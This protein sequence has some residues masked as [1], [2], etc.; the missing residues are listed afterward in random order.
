MAYR[1]LREFTK[2][3][4]QRGLLHRVKVEVDPVLEITEITD[5]IS[6]QGGP[7]LLF[8]QVR[9]S[10]YPVL[11]NTFGSKERMELAFE[12]NHLDEIGERINS[13]FQIQDFSSSSS[14]WD[15]IK[16]LPRLAEMSFWAPK[17]VK[18]APC[19]EVVHI[20]DASLEIFPI[21]K[22]WPGDGGRYITLPLVFTKDPETGLRNVGMYRLQVF[23]ACTTG[24]HW[25][26]HKNGAENYKKHQILGKR[27]EV[28]VALG[29]DPATVYAATAPLPRGFDEILFAGFL[30]QQS[31]E[32]VKCITVDLEVPSQAEIVLEG[33]V[34]LEEKRLEGPFGDHTGYYSLP[35]WYP[36]FHITCITHRRDAI[37]LA[38]VVGKPPMEDCFFAKATERIFLPIIKFYLPEIVDINLPLEGVFHNCV[39]VAIEKSY[40]GQAKKVMCALWGLGQ[41]MFTKMIIVVDAHVNVHDMAEVW[42][43]VYNN[44]DPKRDFLFVEGPVEVLDHAC[45]LPAYG[46]K[47]G[48]DAT[49]KGPGEGHYR[50]WPE[51]IQMSQEIKERVAARWQLY[52]F[53]D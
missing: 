33:Y 28:A 37:Y 38:T 49:K 50:E 9:D 30:R 20:D 19:Q 52:G 22:C 23:D 51:E 13:L 2:V 36:V 26:V 41:M 27:M 24:M 34:D 5:R 6:K 44:V 3:L 25:H 16:L 48:I 46:S 21:L 29:G 4:E 47:V 7:A 8:E 40:F 39:V 15:K 32:I 35:D 11:I 1:D 14:W 17:L 43:R 53:R 10:K 12:V 31:V 45:P 42:W 18:N